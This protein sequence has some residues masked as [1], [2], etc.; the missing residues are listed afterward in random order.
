MVFFLWEEGLS[1]GKGNPDSGSGR[2]KC[3][4]LCKIKPAGSGLGMI[5]SSLKFILIFSRSTLAPS[6]CSSSWRTTV[7]SH[8][9]H[10]PTSPPEGGRML[11]SW[12]SWLCGAWIP[13]VR[14]TSGLSASVALW[15]LC[16][17]VDVHIRA[18]FC[19]GIR[20]KMAA[21]TCKGTANTFYL[22]LFLLELKEAVKLVPHFAPSIEICGWETSPG[23]LPRSLD[24]LWRVY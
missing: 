2:G 24:H 16:A 8:C 14:G 15:L 6:S 19:A 20:Q 17:T 5:Q 12:C 13:H 10:L 11:W 18:K 1:C 21:T 22:F 3:G 9:W 4:L 7:V 23:F